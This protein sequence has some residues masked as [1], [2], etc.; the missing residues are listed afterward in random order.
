[1]CGDAMRITGKVQ[2]IRIPFKLALNHATT[3]DRFV[4]ANVIFG[5]ETAL[6]DTGVS[7]SERAI[8]DVI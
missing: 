4:Y 3:P 8:Y 6:I 7:S 1:M 2:T 5:K